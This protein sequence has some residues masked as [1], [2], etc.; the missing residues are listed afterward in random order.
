MTHRTTQRD[1][2]AAERAK[3]ALSLRKQGYTLDEIAL[4]CS[5]ADKSG[6]HRAI[7]RG[8][9]LVPVDDA[10][11]LRKL[12]NMRL[13]DALK[14]CYPKMQSGDMW[15]V[16]RVVNI[17]RRRSEITGMDVKPDELLA[18]QNYVKKIILTHEEPSTGGQ[19]ASTN[20]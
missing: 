7:K 1:I 4:Q 8:L 14:V 6:A 13:D 9:S 15:A 20:S 3:Q 2:N 18:N 5:Y 19:D 11:E 17:S 16:D 12:E 10:V